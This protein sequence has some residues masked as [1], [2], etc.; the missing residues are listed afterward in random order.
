MNGFSNSSMNWTQ[1]GSPTVRLSPSGNER[2][3]IT[4]LSRIRELAAKIDLLRYGA[5]DE[6]NICTERS[7]EA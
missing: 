2:E 3:V 7:T 4:H 6:P 5:G 1:H